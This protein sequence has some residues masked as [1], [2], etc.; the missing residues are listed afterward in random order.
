MQSK[1]KPAM[2]AAERDYVAVVKSV[3][4]VSCDAQPGVTEAHEIEQGFWYTSIS[5][6]ADCH[7]GDHGIHGDKVYMRI[8]KQTE[9]SLLNETLRRVMRLR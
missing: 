2:T 4:C 5:L 7:R 6:C 8:R 9:L 1:N 3:G